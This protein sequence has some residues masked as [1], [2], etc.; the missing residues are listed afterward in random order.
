LLQES[1]YVFRGTHAEP[2]LKLKVGSSIHYFEGRMKISYY[3]SDYIFCVSVELL[4]PVTLQRTGSF[5]SSQD[6]PR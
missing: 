1:Q 2:M 6:S 5:S 4:S 3:R